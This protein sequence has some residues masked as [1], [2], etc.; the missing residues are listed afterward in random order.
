MLPGSSR[1]RLAH[2][3]KAAY[4]EGVLSEN[5]LVHRLDLLF[6]S[7]L[8]DPAG[9]VGDLQ[10]RR[11]RRP[12]S[13][14]VERTKAA[15]RRFWELRGIGRPS[16]PALLALDWDGGHEELVIGRNPS[17]DIVL[18]GSAVSRIHARLSF[19][20]GSWILQDLGSTNGTVVNGSQVGR[21]KLQ[22][23]DRVV[24]GEEQLLVD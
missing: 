6:D 20:D 24:I 9:L 15:G 12:L 23:G 3:L 8:V 14:A 2:T 11:R 1:Q 13:S 16:P 10:A 5:T 17:C 7:P 22:P 18:A 4:A 21:C 19:R